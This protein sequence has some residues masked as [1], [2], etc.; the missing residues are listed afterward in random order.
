MSWTTSILVVG[1]AGAFSFLIWVSE[2]ILDS[3]DTHR[4]NR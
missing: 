3:L 4:M 2:A 1:V